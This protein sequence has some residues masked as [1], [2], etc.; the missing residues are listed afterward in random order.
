L[1]RHMPPPPAG[2]A[3]LTKPYLVQGDFQS[4]EQLKV[5]SVKPVFRPL[6]KKIYDRGA[7]SE[8]FAVLL[9]L[10]ARGTMRPCRITYSMLS[11][12]M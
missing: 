5:E 11:Q 12:R 4:S 9:V 7:C 10:L 8:G 6:V 3:E 2:F 1:L